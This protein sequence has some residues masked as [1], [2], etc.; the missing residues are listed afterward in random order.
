VSTY[1]MIVNPRTVLKNMIWGVALSSS[2][3]GSFSPCSILYI[4]RKQ[5]RSG[6]LDVFLQ[7]VQINLTIGT[8]HT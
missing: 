4:L 3:A 8:V 2:K 5:A 6:H 1:V 7:F